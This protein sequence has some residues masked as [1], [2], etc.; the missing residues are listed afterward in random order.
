VRRQG[1]SLSRVRRIGRLHSANLGD[2]ATS[3]S[4]SPTDVA[5]ASKLRRYIVRDA[6][7]M[8]TKFYR[9]QELV[10][11]QPGQEGPQERV[12]SNIPYDTPSTALSAIDKTDENDRLTQRHP[13]Y[14]EAQDQQIPFPQGYRPQVQTQPQT[15]S[16]RHHEGPGTWRSSHHQPDAILTTSTEG[17]Q[18]WQER[19]R[20]NAST[21]SRKSKIG[22]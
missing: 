9:V 16:S 3:T 2:T 12:R 4:Y 21:T 11:A 7:G 10:A 6:D 15:C 14:Q 13:Q 22:V 5:M 18:G 1:H 20:I 17:G 19:V 8:L